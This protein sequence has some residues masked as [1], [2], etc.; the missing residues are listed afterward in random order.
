MAKARMQLGQ[1]G[2][3]GQVQ[4]R[5]PSVDI[6][7]YNPL[8]MNTSASPRPGQSVFNVPTMQRPGAQG[9]VFQN[10]TGNLRKRV[11]AMLGEPGTPADQLVIF[12]T[13]QATGPGQNGFEA[14]VT[15]PCNAAMNWVSC[16]SPVMPSKKAAMQEASAVALESYF[17]TP[18]ASIPGY[19]GGQR[20]MP[21]AMATPVQTSLASKTL[22]KKSKVIKMK[23]AKKASTASAAAPLDKFFR[24]PMASFP[25]YGAGNR[26]VPMGAL[27]P[28]DEARI[29]AKRL[30]KK[31]KAIKTKLAKKAAAEAQ[32]L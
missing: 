14:T 26:V 15:F 27:T 17:H 18:R 20:V 24:S 16:S 6:V 5:S 31:N 10:F 29:A 19:E 28:L 22:L 32:G 9:F 8:L 2:M 1:M 13:T 4:T 25:G 3:T 23:S 11:L 12:T 7:F 21:M 30:K